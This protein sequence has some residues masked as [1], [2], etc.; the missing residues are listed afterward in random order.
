MSG[1]H[2]TE[3]DAEAHRG[4]KANIVD[5]VTQVASARPVGL[6][7]CQNLSSASLETFIVSS[8]GI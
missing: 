3:R 8:M 2:F 4:K 6:Q 1:F 7:L 5:R